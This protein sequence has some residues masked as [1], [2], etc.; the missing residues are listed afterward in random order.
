[1]RARKAQTAMAIYEALETR[2][3]GYALRIPA[4]KNLELAIE[5]LLFRSPGRRRG[6]IL[7]Q[8]ALWLV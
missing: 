1:M 5:D 3:V 8:A 6:G 4:N 2:D 7:T